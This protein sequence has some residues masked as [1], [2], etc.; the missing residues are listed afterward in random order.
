MTISFQ[1]TLYRQEN[2]IWHYIRLI[3]REASHSFEV[4]TA[5]CGRVATPIREEAVLPGETKET[6]LHRL[7]VALKQAGYSEHPGMDWYLDVQIFTPP[8]DGRATAAPWFNAL[9]SDILHPLYEVLEETANGGY[10]DGVGTETECITHFL[11]VLD[12]EAAMK[13]IETI[14]IKTPALCRIQANYR[15][16]PEEPV[17]DKPPAPT[18]VTAGSPE[19]AET[20]L[21]LIPPTQTGT[22][23]DIQGLAQ[24]LLNLTAGIAE[25]M[26]QVIRPYMETRPVTYPDSPN[27]WSAHAATN[28]VLGEKAKRLRERLET[29][30]GI[31]K[32]YWP[33]LGGPAP[34]ET[35][36]V[37][38]E[39]LED[40][41]GAKLNAIIQNR[42]IGQ[43]YA[44]DESG[45]IFITDAAENLFFRYDAWDTFRFDDGM[46]WIVYVTHENTV[47]FGGDW[48]LNEVREL[49][50][51]QP[52]RLNPWF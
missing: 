52:E 25:E 21:P 30:W 43:V 1:K 29:Q 51:E 17:P 7:A 39:G 50:K 27:V 38:G 11:W 19:K 16:S 42:M 10:R 5:P 23:L 4:C 46:E 13:A 20:P 2:N 41:I 33:P 9:Q 22:T 48:L 14:A 6:A 18:G 12:P 32:G 31:G 37:I 44:F 8:W 3:W 15:K 26:K 47:T 49:F 40:K 45:D 28:R 36:H 34:C 24:H 35:L